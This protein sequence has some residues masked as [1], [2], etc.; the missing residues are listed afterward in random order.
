MKK[1]TPSFYAIIPANIR[2][3]DRLAPNAKLLYGE[4]TA[5]ANKEGHCWASNDYFAK[6]YS[7]TKVSVSKWV[8]QL[9]EYGYIDT[10]LVYKEGSKEIANRYIRIVY[11]PIKENFNTPIKEKFKD[12]TTSNNNTINNT[13]NNGD[14]VP[15]FSSLG[16]DIIKEMEKVDPKNKMYYGRPVQREACEFLIQEYTFETVV[17][18]I[19]FYVLARGKVKY[20]PSISTPCELRDKWSKLQGL[21]ERKNA[22]NSEAI[23]NVV[24]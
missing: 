24:W 11:D 20:L 7:V 12:N 21:I 3:D 5:L 14:T 18:V 6:L 19:R 22:E 1:E 13:N 8:S 10:E 23:N 2:Y 9:S 15:K 17:Q 16:A 4:I